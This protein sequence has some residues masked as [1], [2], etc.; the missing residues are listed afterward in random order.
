[1]LL[2]EAGRHFPQ[3]YSLAQDFWRRALH[4]KVHLLAEYLLGVDNDLADLLSR[5]QQQIHE[6]KLHPQVLHLYFGRSEIPNIDLYG[7]AEYAKCPNVHP[8][9]HTHKRRAMHYE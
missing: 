9:I 6:W 3:L 8:G 7:T 4:H 1:M 5:M 2:T